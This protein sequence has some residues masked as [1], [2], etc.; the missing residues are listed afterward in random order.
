MQHGY[1]STSVNDIA[2][3]LGITKAGLYH[4]I[5]SKESLLFDILTLGV[6]A[7]EDEVVVPTRT[8]TDPED[9]LNDIVLRHAILVTCNR[10]ALTLLVDTLHALP[11]AQRREISARYRRYFTYLRD[12][13]AELRATGRLRD[14]DPTVAAFSVL[15]VILW[16]PQWFRPDGRLTSEEVAREIVAF[17]SAALISSAVPPRRT[18]LRLVAGASV[19]AD[20][21]EPRRGRGRRE[22]RAF[23]QRNPRR[24]RFCM[25]AARALVERGFQGTSVSDIASALG[26]TEAG[27]YHH[28]ASKDQLFLEI[29]TLGMD[30]LDEDVVKPVAEVSD[31]ETRLS[32]IISRHARLT[33]TNEPWI[34]VLQDDMRAMPAA[35]RAVIG[36]RKRAYFDLM[37]GLV[38]DL[39]TMGSVRPL[40]STVATYSV[41]A[42]ILWIPRWLN[43]KGRLHP[44]RVAEEVADI[45]LGALFTRRDGPGRLL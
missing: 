41:L 20:R 8:I 1:D 11:R 27:L 37:R 44:E 23:A 31:A 15:G 29:L 28:I 21:P 45:A 14:L 12:T 2:S 38:R 24:V 26:V 34:T 10:G 3:A 25:T 9:R 32:Q 4:Y 42:M 33:A 30:W 22:A 35:D 13:I 39:Q 19:G 16:M 36:L 40:D 7:L 5:T 6:D 43:P 18:P 17:V